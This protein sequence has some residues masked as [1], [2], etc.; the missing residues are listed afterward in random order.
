MSREW[1]F[2]TVI[3]LGQIAYGRI[4]P[5]ASSGQHIRAIRVLHHLSCDS[6]PHQS[7]GPRIIMHHIRT[8]ADQVWSIEARKIPH[9]L[10]VAA[11]KKCKY[12]SQDCR[13][14]GRRQDFRRAW[15]K[16]TCTSAFLIARL[17][18]KRTLVQPG[19]MLAQ[20]RDVGCEKAMWCLGD[21]TNLALQFCLN[22]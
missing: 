14:A 13:R 2:W 5:S 20:L 8:P 18:F 16:R 22:V 6:D 10:C 3:F 21:G 1:I 4:S 19:L 12:S 17:S 15:L 7:P 9:D 11:M